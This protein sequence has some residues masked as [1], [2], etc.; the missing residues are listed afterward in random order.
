MENEWTR[1][2]DRLRAENE[3]LRGCLELALKYLEHPDVQEI[4]FSLHTGVAAK[5]IRTALAG[6]GKDG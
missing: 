3:R 2:I 4:P 1:E 6:G 5:R